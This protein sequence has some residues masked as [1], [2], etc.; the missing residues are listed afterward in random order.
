LTPKGLSTKPRAVA[1]ESTERARAKREYLVAGALAMAAAVLG[2]AFEPSD[3]AGGSQ[4]L[5]LVAIAVLAA[6]MYGR[7]AYGLLRRSDDDD[8]G[9]NAERMRKMAIIWYLLAGV[10][11]AAILRAPYSV[12]TTSGVEGLLPREWVAGALGVAILGAVAGRLILSLVSGKRGS[13]GAT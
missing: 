10:L 12:I 3:G 8:S 7:V 11:G 1:D 6:V 4:R 5:E 2:V 13:N 9:P